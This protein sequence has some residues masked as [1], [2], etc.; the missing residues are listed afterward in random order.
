MRGEYFSVSDVARPAL[1]SPPL[2]R[3]IRGTIFCPAASARIT[4]ACAGNTMGCTRSYLTR[5]DHPRLRGEYKAVHFFLDDY[6]GSPP[7]AQGIRST[8]SSG[9]SCIRIT[10][11][12]AGNTP[13]LSSSPKMY[14]DHPRLRGEYL[15]STRACMS[16]LGSPPLARG[17]QK[18]ERRKQS[19]RGITPACAGNTEQPAHN[20]SVRRDHPRLR[21]EY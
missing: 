11:A 7:L 14:R 4:P 18:S 15:R 17:I 16:G 8:K 5:W 13:N 1:G 21:G 10:P 2:A 9:I 19:G 12:C 3:G 20:R 6:Q